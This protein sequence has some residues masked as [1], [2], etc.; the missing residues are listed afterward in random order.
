MR[1]AEE[2]LL[3]LCHPLGQPV[4]PLRGWEYRELAAR[5]SDAPPDEALTAPA[6]EHSAG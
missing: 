5:F 2:L 3:L 4:Q 6:L 1:H